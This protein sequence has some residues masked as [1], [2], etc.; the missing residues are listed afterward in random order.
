LLSELERRGFDVGVQP[1]R[2]VPATPQRVLLDAEA[3]ARVHLATGA[4]VERWRQVPGA[5]QIA[6]FD[7]R[8]ADARA[9]QER[10]RAEVTATL[11]DLGLDELVPK[12]DLN[13]FGAAIDERVPDA[14]QEQMGR[15][16]A[17]GGPLAVFVVP[18]DTPEP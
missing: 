18:V 13:L 2:R 3:T 8:D 16:L 4:F 15:M 1:G 12:L 14:T 5:V 10:L 6:S 17:L 9:E 7:P 11:L